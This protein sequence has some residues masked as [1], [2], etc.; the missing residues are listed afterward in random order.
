MA[1]I[2][3]FSVCS[4]STSNH[5][6]ELPIVLVFGIATCVSSVHN[7]LSNAASACLCMEKF[8]A[9]PSTEYLT[10]V[11]NQVSTLS[12]Y[13]TQVRRYTFLSFELYLIYMF[14]I[15]LY[16][17]VSGYRQ[18]WIFVYVLLI[19]CRIAESFPK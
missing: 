15:L 5:L 4:A 7:L 2:N 12:L 14:L 13:F 19:D 17:R 10:E 9:P 3:I 1:I 11:I 6:N 16:E 8:Q 18:L